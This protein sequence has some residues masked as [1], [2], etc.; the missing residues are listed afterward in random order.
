[1]GTS[2]IWEIAVPNGSYQVHIVSGDPSYTD[3]VDKINVEGV[4]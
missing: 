2:N 4:L 1:M 3:S